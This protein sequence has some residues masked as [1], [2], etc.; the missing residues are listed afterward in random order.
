[1]HANLTDNME[2]RKKKRS[3]V[4]ANLIDNM[5]GRKDGSPNAY[6]PKGV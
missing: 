2:K 5:K 1:M 6:L 3:D 4:Q